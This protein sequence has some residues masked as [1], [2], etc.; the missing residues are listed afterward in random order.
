MKIWRNVDQRKVWSEEYGFGVV[1]AERSDGILAI[2][3]DNNPWVMRYINHS[4][5]KEVK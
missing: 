1:T 5:V 2:Q 3:F 4:E